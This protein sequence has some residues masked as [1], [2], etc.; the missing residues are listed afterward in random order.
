MQHCTPEQLALAALREPLPAADAAHLERCDACRSEVATLRRAP[1]LLSVPQ[2]AAPGASVPPPPRVWD[3]IAAATGVSAVPQ[4]SGTPATPPVVVAPPLPAEPADDAD[5]PGGTVV[6]FRS[7]RRPLLLAAAAV[8]AGAVVGAGAVAVVQRADGDGEAVTTVALAPLPDAEASG[9]A[10][11]VVKDDGSRVLELELEA[12]ALE[13][14]YY[15]VWL[16][17]RSVDGMF[18]LGVVRPGTQTVELPAGLDLAE[19]P[20]VDVSVEPLDGE[21]THS[22]V[23]VARGGS[24]RLSGALA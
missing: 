7:R 17:D 1:D 22:G 4:T 20:L 5:R 18:S 8:V 2:L 24:R 10:D 9:V 23:S 13:G 16:I 14:S 12:P 11:V 6:P 15:E 19:F 3:A 21:P